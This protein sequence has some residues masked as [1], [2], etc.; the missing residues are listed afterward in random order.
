MKKLTTFTLLIL[1]ITMTC[2]TVTADESGAFLQALVP[3]VVN[4]L[5]LVN[6]EISGETGAQTLAGTAVCIDP[7]SGLMLTMALDPRLQTENISKLEVL[8]PGQPAKK[9]AAKLLGIDPVTGISFLQVSGHVFS[10]VAFMKQ[11]NVDIGQR[12]ASVCLTGNESRVAPVLGT[13]FVASKQRMPDWRFF[14]TGGTLSQPGS[15]VFD[16]KGQAVGLVGNQPFQRF[17]TT[18]KRGPVTLPLKSEDTAVSFLPAEEF[19]YILQDI[20]QDGQVRRVP[21][22]GVINFNPVAPELA[23]AKGIS[24]PAVMVGQI[25]PGSAAEKAGL[26]DRDIVIAIDGAPIEDL[27]SPDLIVAGFMRTIAKL[28]SGNTVKLT[29]LSGPNKHDV[30]IQL[31]PMP[32]RPNEAPTLLSKALGL[33]L[34]EKVPMDQYLEPGPA[35]PVPG[36]LVLAVGENSPA[37]KGGLEKDDVITEINGTPVKT[38]EEGKKILNDAMQQT[39]AMNISLLVKRGDEDKKIM[40]RI[41]SAK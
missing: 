4:S 23:S 39:T 16:S 22:L 30:N 24:V 14:I 25:V 12:V 32:M 11:A 27:G 18:S 1:A 5:A 13:G 3:K 40:I 2:N 9:V 20:P 29:V 34:R 33:L 35:G 7:G 17:Q 15:I 21:W 26:A 6:C 31:T 36:L 8:I 19:V 28:G 41:P 10:A 37:S 38:A